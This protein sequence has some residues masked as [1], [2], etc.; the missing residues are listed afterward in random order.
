MITRIIT[1]AVGMLC[2]S[3][4]IGFTPLTNLVQQRSSSGL[5]SSS[6]I[7]SVLVPNRSP[8]LVL[9]HSTA[10]DQSSTTT[11]PIILNGQHIDLTPAL[12]EYVNKRIGGI[13]KKLASSGSVRECDVV[14]SV[15]RNPK[16]CTFLQNDKRKQKQKISYMMCIVSIENQFL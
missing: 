4:V 10:E 14:L 8:H 6:R 7:G 5:S 13:L 16:V 15:N 2:A 11:V 1:A 12:V 9:L 3:N